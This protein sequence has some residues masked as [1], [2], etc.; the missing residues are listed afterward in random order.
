MPSWQGWDTDPLKYKPE[1]GLEVEQDGTVFDVPQ[2]RRELKESI[3]T[4]AASTRTVISS[5]HSRV[6]A[7]QAFMVYANDS[8]LGNGSTLNIK[9][10]TGATSPHLI[11]D[12]HGK[13]D[14]EF[15][16]HEGPTSSGGSASTIYNKNRASATASTL[17]AVGNTSSI[18]GGTIIIHD[19]VSEG[20]KAGGRVD[21]ERE[22]ILK[23]STDYIFEITSLA[24][25]NLV[26]INLEWYEPT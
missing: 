8:N 18:S 17:T 26:H 4:E 5:V 2:W 7:G 24:G 19:L 6:H 15:K 22:L 9:L 3:D 10:T 14:F 13:L 25:N 12:V 11:F 20:H 23:A 1:V 16:C 21:F